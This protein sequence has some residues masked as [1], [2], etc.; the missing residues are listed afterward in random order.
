MKI[1][2]EMLQGKACQEQVNI[3]QKLFSNEAELTKSNF[4]LAI[5]NGLEV[6]W[7]TRYLTDSAWA[8]YEKIRDS[9][10]WK[11]YSDENNWKAR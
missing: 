11:I 10:L 1:T 4:N 3:F 7:L 8:D 6:E 2:L 5:A 9:A